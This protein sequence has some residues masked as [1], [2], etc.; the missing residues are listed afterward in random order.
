MT[1]ADQLAEAITPWWTQDFEDLA[2]AV[3]S[4]FVHA[5][6]YCADSE[7]DGGPIG[8][9]GVFSTAT[10]PAEA[11]PYLAQWVGEVLRAGLAEPQQREWI[12]DR[13]N[14]RRGTPESIALAAQRT[15]IGQR[16]VQLFERT[17]ADGSAD[18]NGDNV[19]VYT[20][21]ADTPDQAQVLLDM[22]DVMFVDMVLH[23]VVLP[24]PTWQSVQTAEPTWAAVKSAYVTWGDVKA[25]P[26]GGM[27][28]SRQAV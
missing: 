9:E 2:R 8:W 19:L 17:M 14:S 11:L 4:M 16:T 6:S 22:Q 23:Y 5:E 21:A 24:F 20:Y 3:G 7:L 1:V 28:W 12:D 25:A 10:C 13:P 15:L 18:A 27:S 26:A